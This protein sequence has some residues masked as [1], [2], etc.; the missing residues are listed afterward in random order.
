[1]T[2]TDLHPETER[3]D[4]ESPAASGRSPA[5]RSRSSRRT[6]LAALGAAGLSAVAGCSA[7]STTGSGADESTSATSSGPEAVDPRFG[8]VGSGDETPPVDP[9]HEVRLVTRPR[10]GVPIPEFYFEPTGLAVDVGDTVRFTLTTPHH[11]V[12]AYHPA[13]GFTR[14]VPE[15][16]PPFSSPV[17]PADAYWL[18]TVRHEGVHDVMCSPHE[19]F[20]MVGRVVA[21]SPT[22]PAA[23]PVGEAPG[24]ER[25][26]SPELT[27]GL[28]LSDP[29]LTPEAVAD[30]GSVSWS[31]LSAESKRPLLRPVEE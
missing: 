20:G 30:E 31:A 5:G 23:A 11:N 15:A 2:T 16:A 25:A 24:G 27:A 17:L 18:Y 9:D 4:S 6:V 26:R 29:A 1:M 19:L 12:N 14:R 22:G 7:G 21:G 8:F 10:E 28:V 13:F 3:T